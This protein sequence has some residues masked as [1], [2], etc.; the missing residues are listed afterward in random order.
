MNGCDGAWWDG[1]FELLNICGAFGSRSEN[2]I[3]ILTIDNLTTIL[4]LNKS[5]TESTKQIIT[6]EQ[7]I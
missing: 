3:D 1:V 7:K 5:R 6:R 4:N 2:K